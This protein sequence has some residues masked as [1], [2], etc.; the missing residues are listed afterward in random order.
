M[1]GRGPPG[2]AV[3]LRPGDVSVLRP[4]EQ[5]V[6][7]KLAGVIAASSVGER[8]SDGLIGLHAATEW[9]PYAGSNG[10]TDAPRRSKSGPTG[11]HTRRT[12][13]GVT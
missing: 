1:T 13:Q 8:A 3:P 10:T 7:G 12:T 4:T 6:D 5:P 11:G 9:P 2:S